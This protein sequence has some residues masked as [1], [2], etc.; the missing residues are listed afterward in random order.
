MS[1]FKKIIQTILS[2]FN[3]RINKIRITNETSTIE[4]IFFPKLSNSTFFVESKSAVGWVFGVIN[5]YKLLA[6]R[7]DKN[8][9]F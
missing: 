1:F 8:F 5:N 7:I 4:K 6:Y 2:F 9:N 3:L